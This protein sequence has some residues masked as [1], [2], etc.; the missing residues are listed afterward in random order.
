MNWVTLIHLKGYIPY[1]LSG[2]GGIDSKYNFTIV[3][4]STN[5]ERAPLYLMKCLEALQSISQIPK[6]YEGEG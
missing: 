1:T 2:I 6:E 4:I 5:L 3:S